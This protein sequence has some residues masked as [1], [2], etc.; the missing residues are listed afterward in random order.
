MDAQW[1]AETFPLMRGGGAFLV[2]IGLG[3]VAGSFGS[4]RW[5]TV[6]LIIGA[7]V[8]VLI[9]SIGGATKLIFAGLPS[10]AVWQWVV[11]G[12]AFL[13]EGY[14]VSV[15]V[16]R[17]PDVESRE[18]WMWMLFI[19][20][21]HFLILGASHGPVCAVLAIVCM[22]N[23]YIGLKSTSIDF[24]VFW[25]IDGALKVLGGAAMIALSLA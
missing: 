7:A 16:R 17:F 15:V 11:L 24:R 20:G 12:V 22:V 18:F 23:A 14:L 4:R 10:P 19:V 1:L 9:M 5:R 25:G 21:A 8:G 13:V 6:N 2:A 3:I